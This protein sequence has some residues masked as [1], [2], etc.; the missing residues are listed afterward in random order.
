MPEGLQKIGAVDYLLQ[1]VQNAG[2][3]FTSMTLVMTALVGVTAVLTGSGVAA[4]SLSPARLPPL[5]QNLV[6]ALSI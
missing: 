2:T 3:G 1:S 6:R 5:R 4:F